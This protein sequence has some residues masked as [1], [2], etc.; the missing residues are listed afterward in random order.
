MGVFA[1]VTNLDPNPRQCSCETLDLHRKKFGFVTRTDAN[2]DLK[3]LHGQ[4]RPFEFK[5]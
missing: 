1:H 4:R 5:P 2:P 3:I